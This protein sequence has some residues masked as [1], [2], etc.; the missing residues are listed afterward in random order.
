MPREPL[1]ADKSKRRKPSRKKAAP[2]LQQTAHGVALNGQDFTS[3]DMSPMAVHMSKG[4]SG[5]LRFCWIR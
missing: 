2:Y 4:H 1:T 5:T 3:R